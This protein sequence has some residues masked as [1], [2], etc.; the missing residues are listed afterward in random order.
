MV[1]TVNG[2]FDKNGGP[3]AW[4]ASGIYLPAVR[5]NYPVADAQTKPGSLACFFGSEERIK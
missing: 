3:L 4:L 2:Q 1:A 5:G